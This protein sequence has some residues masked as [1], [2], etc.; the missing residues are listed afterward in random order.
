MCKKK[1]ENES[2]KACIS[3]LL[4]FRIVSFQWFMSKKIKKSASVPTR[5]WGCAQT[6]LAPVLVAPHAPRSLD[7]ADGKGYTIGFRFRKGFAQISDSR[8][9]TAI[10]PAILSLEFGADTDCA[11][12]LAFAYRRTRKATAKG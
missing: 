6:S 10:D 4:F 11:L 1:Q 12:R 9:A 3:F 5:A 2:K 8:Q 7:P